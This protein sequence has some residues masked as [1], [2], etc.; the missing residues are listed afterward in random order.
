M[1]APRFWSATWLSWSDEILHTVGLTA[2][3]LRAVHTVL[4]NASLTPPCHRSTAARYPIS[5][6]QTGLI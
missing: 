3:Q 4:D 5:G 2:R 6:R 1:S